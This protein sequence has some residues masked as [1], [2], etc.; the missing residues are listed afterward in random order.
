MYRWWHNKGSESGSIPLFVLRALVNGWSDKIHYVHLWLVVQAQ[1]YHVCVV[2]PANVK[3][4]E[5]QKWEG[6]GTGQLHYTDLFLHSS[7]ATT[8]LT[9]YLVLNVNSGDNCATNSPTQ[10]PFE[11]YIMK[12]LYGNNVPTCPFFIIEV[13]RNSKNQHFNPAPELPESKAPREPK[14]TC[15]ISSA[16]FSLALIKTSHF[17]GPCLLSLLLMTSPKNCS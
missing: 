8:M 4:Q 16:C 17:A 12:T 5:I 14:P 9:C 2:T 7:V 3:R 6:S 15:K 10:N 1:E 11:F 13:L